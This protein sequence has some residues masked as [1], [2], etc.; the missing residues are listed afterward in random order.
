MQRYKI[1]SE[2]LTPLGGIFQIMKQ[3]NICPAT[4]LNP[5]CYAASLIPSIETPSLRA[6]QKREIVSMEISF[7]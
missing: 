3:F 2:K 5:R 1:K 6:K 4:V 7:P